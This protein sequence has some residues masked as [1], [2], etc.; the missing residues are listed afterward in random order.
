MTGGGTS[1]R[2]RRCDGYNQRGAG[3]CHQC[4]SPFIPNLRQLLMQE[5]STPVY[6]RGGPPASYSAGIGKGG[7]KGKTGQG[8]GQSNFGLTGKGKGQSNFGAPPGGFGKGKGAGDF[9][10]NGLGKGQS[11]FGTPPENQEAAFG[12]STW[13]GPHRVRTR[14]PKAVR[15]AAIAEEFLAEESLASCS[16]V[17]DSSQ[18]FATARHLTREAERMSRVCPES[19]AVAHAKA[20]AF[21]QQGRELMPPAQLVAT[22][23]KQHGDLFAEAGRLRGQIQ[24]WQTKL[25]D[26]SREGNEVRRQLDLAKVR[27]AALPSPPQPV[28]PDFAAA[29]QFFHQA[30]H[31]LPH[32]QMG[33][34]GECLERIQRAMLEDPHPVAPAPMEEGATPSVV[35]EVQGVDLSVPDGSGEEEFPPGWGETTPVALPQ[36]RAEAMGSSSAAALPS[37]SPPRGRASGSAPQV[38]RGSAPPPPSGA[39]SRSHS[40]SGDRRGRSEVD[41]F[42]EGGSRYFPQ[43]AERQGLGDP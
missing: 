13:R 24:S 43:S 10:W 32:D 19:A 38:R 4:G 2:C 22:L 31:F 1:W 21:H 27:L 8:S 28:R 41:L 9:A 5:K 20:K 35:A 33:F 42:L 18:F 26:V 23:E 11:N 39:R 37:A 14:K 40:L 7:G 16:E 34:F 12:P 29:L 15:D 30:S 25:E 36:Q 3:C 17:G 6:Y